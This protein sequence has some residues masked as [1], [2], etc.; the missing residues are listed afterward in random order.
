MNILVLTTRDIYNDG[1]EKSLMQSK[2]ENLKKHGYN[3]FYYS[4][5]RTFDGTKK[6]KFNIVKQNSTYALFYKKHTIYKHILHL[7]EQY[8]CKII[9]ISGVWLYFLKQKL[10]DIKKLTGVK[11]SLDYQGALEEINEYKMVFNN[12]YLS[13]KIY[14][15]LKNREEGIISISDGIE[16]VSRN[17]ISHIHSS[18]PNISKKQFATV[19][20]GIDHPLSYHEYQKNRDFWRDEFCLDNKQQVSCVYA[21]GI[22]KW[23]RIEDI[24]NMAMNNKKILFFIFTSQS[25]QTIL[26]KQYKIPDNLKLHYLPHSTLTKALCAFDYG[27]LFRNIDKTN[28]VAF[29]NKYSEYINA[30]LKVLLLNSNIGC[31]P[32]SKYKNSTLIISNTTNTLNYFSF[33]NNNDI[34]LYTKYIE[35]LDYKNLINQLTLY[36]GK[37]LIHE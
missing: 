2:D 3:L 25:N 14:N 7:I 11:I 6:N 36:Y 18:Y 37:L 21:G 31:Y 9:V 15:Y 12:K 10:T 29:P 26:K 33:A 8:E 30:R 34:D 16:T 23:Q 1:G 4:F 35:Y 22:H 28:F 24:I 19:H 20:C 32:P 17:C 13:Y 27:I 5:R